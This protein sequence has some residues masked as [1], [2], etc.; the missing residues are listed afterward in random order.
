M[1]RRGPKRDDAARRRILD[2]TR[3]LICEHGPG[4]VTINQITAS[5]HVGKQTIY[6]WW[7]SRSALVVDALADLV[8]EQA[9]IIPEGDQAATARDA[10]AQHMLRLAAT[11]ESPAG[12]MIRELVGDAQGDTAVAGLFHRRFMHERRER[13][14]ATLQSGIDRGELRSDLSIETMLDVLYAPFWF[15]L[16]LDHERL[17]SGL[18]EEILTIVWPGL[19]PQP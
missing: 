4:R 5:A 13:A 10:V 7:P 17:D 18:G 12:A 14:A 3:D 16:L 15:R 9:F 8:E 19:T 6:R 2:A 1:A 11:F